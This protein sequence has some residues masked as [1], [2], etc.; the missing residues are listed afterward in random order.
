MNQ[1]KL[2]IRLIINKVDE[3]DGWGH[4]NRKI[5]TIQYVLLEGAQFYPVAMVYHVRRFHLWPFTVILN[6]YRLFH[7]CPIWS[8]LNRRLKRKCLFPFV[9]DL[10]IQ[11]CSGTFEKKCSE[12]FW[13][14]SGAIFADSKSAHRIGHRDISYNLISN[15][16]NKNK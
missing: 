12:L 13:H 10:L 11:F 2:S 4:Q 7:F 14:W 5:W 9:I 16:I 1:N 6:R 15:E 3:L 8:F